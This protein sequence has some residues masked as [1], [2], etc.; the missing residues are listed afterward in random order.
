MI[1]IIGGGI[2]GLSAAYELAQRG[3]P[4][5][6]FEATPRVGGLIHTDRSDGYTIEAGADSLLVQKPAGLQLCDALGLGD[7][8][9]STTPPR[10]AFILKHGRL[11]P[12]PAGAVLGIP[13]GWRAIARY[14]LLSRTARARLSLEP[15]IPAADAGDESVGAFFR[16]RFGRATVDL[17]AQPLLGGIHA[18][19]VEQLSIRSLFPRFPDAEAHTGSILRAFGRLAGGA[20]DGLFRTPVTGMSAIVEALERRLPGGTIARGTPVTAM[21]R[22][23]AGWR[24][25]TPDEDVGARAVIL[26]VPAHSAA[27]LLAPVDS[28]ASTLCAAVP[29]V[30]TVSVA[31]AWPR[32]AIGHPLAGSGF[33][34]ARRHN[35]LRLTACSWVTSKWA[36]RAPEGMTL[37]RAFLGG[38]HDPSAVDA[39][40]GQLIDTVA[41]ELA[42]TLHIEGPPH[43]ARAYRWRDAGAQH[44]VGHRA[45]LDAIEARLTRHP[46][47]FVAGSGFRS[48]GIPDCIADGRAAAAG[49]VAES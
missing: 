41:R 29:Y 48:I 5:R 20:S 15:F 7:R 21:G 1:A 42:A 25:V 33:V 27:A 46:G 43:L 31:L 13:T 23:G 24:L 12:L 2:T 45:R 11:F 38:A 26:A 39:S 40:D 10:T 6:V 9:I 34:V 35:A 3:V 28:T 4:C 47:L 37:L 14:D 8:L 16:R 30:S 49:A 22:Y 19:D 17:I 36:H 18:G 32:A 44:H